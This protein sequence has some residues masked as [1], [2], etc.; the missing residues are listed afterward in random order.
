MSKKIRIKI[1]SLGLIITAGINLVGCQ[2]AKSDS[3]YRG[4]ENL[5]GTFV[6]YYPDE[7][8]YDYED[9]DKK[10]YGNF[11]ENLFDEDIDKYDFGN[12]K[13]YSIFLHTE[14]EGDD[15]LNGII[16]D[17]IFG[18]FKISENID[19]EAN[20][21]TIIT[22]ENDDIVDDTDYMNITSEQNEISATMY[23]TSKF[24]GIFKFNPIIKEDKKYYTKLEGKSIYIDGIKKEGSTSLSEKSE[25]TTKNSNGKSISEKFIY[26][27][28]VEIVDELKNIRVKEMNDNDTVI[29]TKEIIHKN[30]EYEYKISK[31]TAYIIIEETCV[32]ENN[33]EITKRSIS[34]RNEIKNDETYHFCNYAN[35]DGI[36]IP[37]LLYIKK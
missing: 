23:V 27:I 12:L 7:D 11:G 2:L 26:N 15:K 9:P 16:S 10:Y 3:E 24:K 28:T 32:D 19:S 33:K 34:D 25:T 18:Q 21:N 4:K 37:K 6:T 22:T 20:D 1:L 17:N 35:E 29:K 5:C 14:G 30:D 31:D 36:V 13:G 8:S